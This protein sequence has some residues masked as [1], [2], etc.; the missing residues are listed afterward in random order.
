MARIGKGVLGGFQ[1][2]VGNVVGASWRDIDYIRTRPRRVKRE[3]SEKQML[4]RHKFRVGLDFMKMVKQAFEVGHIG[5]RF[6]RTTVYSESFGHVLNDVIVGEYPNFRIDHSKVEISKGPL[7]RLHDLKWNSTAEGKIK[8]SW[9]NDRNLFNS[10]DTD[11]V[12]VLLMDKERELVWLY[13]A[14]QRKDLMM[15]LSLTS[16]S[17]RKNLIAWAF[18]Y[19]E[20][21]RRCSDSEFLSEIKEEV[22]E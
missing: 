20:E 17:D 18:V 15:E 12:I 13:G 22:V 10:D 6:T 16:S 9:S 19:N 1:G 4:Q 2:T 21:S 3:P 5:V 7:L 8:V 14:V 11:Q